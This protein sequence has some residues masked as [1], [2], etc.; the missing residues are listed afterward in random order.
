[1]LQ[2]SISYMKLL[3]SHKA[4]LLKLALRFRA[5]ENVRNL[6]NQPERI[7]FE[8]VSEDNIPASASTSVKPL[9][10]QEQTN[11]RTQQPTE[12]TQN[13][14]QFQPGDSLSIGRSVSERLNTNS[15][16]TRTHRRLDDRPTPSGPRTTQ[17]RSRASHSATR[18]PGQRVDRPIL[19]TQRVSEQWR[20]VG[21]HAEPTGTRAQP[22]ITNIE[23]SGARAHSNAATAEP[24]NYQSGA[25]TRQPDRRLAALAQGNEQLK[26]DNEQLEATNS[27]KNQFFQE[28]QSLSTALSKLMDKQEQRESDRKEHLAALASQLQS[29]T[30]TSQQQNQRLPTLVQSLTIQLSTD[31]QLDQDLQALSDTLIRFTDSLIQ[32][33]Q[34]RDEQLEISSYPASG[35]NRRSTADI[36]VLDQPTLYA[37][38]TK[39]AASRSKPSWYAVSTQ[40][41]TI[42]PE[43]E[44]FLANRMKANTIELKASHLSIITHPQEITRLI[45][46]AAGLSGR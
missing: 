33:E 14:Q 23:R 11:G 37:S 42:V 12:P 18:Q 22:P 38:K 34:A 25:E 20:G 10:E 31:Q 9:P 6:I 4:E 29:L 46:N 15:R 27:L 24:A 2:C 3:R 26:Q 30:E 35:T 17:L 1:M 39:V 7:Q 19:R 21:R 8:A 36:P 40:D 5:K 13:P 32:R 43:L 44:R 16:T 45:L 41:R 28:L